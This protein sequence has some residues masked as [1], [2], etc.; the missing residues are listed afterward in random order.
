MQSLPQISS[1]RFLAV[2]GPTTLWFVTQICLP[3][4]SFFE[5]P[6]Q[7]PVLLYLTTLNGLHMSVNFNL[8]F[9][10]VNSTSVYY[11]NQKHEHFHFVVHLDFQG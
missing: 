9:S 3:Q 7:A 1:T 2:T 11:L 4:F 8:D 10:P 6:H 5:Q